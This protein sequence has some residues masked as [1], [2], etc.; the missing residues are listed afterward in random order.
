MAETEFDRIL[1]NLIAVAGK[2]ARGD[3]D[4]VDTLL[5]MTGA[6]HLPPKIQALAESFGMM[7]VQVEAREFK[8]GMTIDALE[9][10]QVE[11]ERANYDALTGLP[12]R[13]IFHDRLRKGVAAAQAGGHKMAV[14]FIDLDRFK[15]VNDNLG[16]AAGDALLRQV[17]KRLKECVRDDDIIARMGGDEFTAILP[18][19]GALEDACEIAG[20]MVKALRQPFDLDGQEAN[21]GCSIGIALSPMHGDSPERL[22]NAA[23]AAMYKAKEAGRNNYQTAV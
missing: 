18:K 15:W 5:T 21:I 19:V 16:H 22:L 12:N 14:M 3:Y 4:D 10:T 23:D 1:D 17:A 13:V 2:I 11:L 7:L 9:R 6:D 20:R 8:L